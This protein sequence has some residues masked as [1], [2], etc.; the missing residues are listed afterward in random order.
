MTSRWSGSSFSRPYGTSP[1]D[2][3]NAKTSK[4][5]NA[6]REPEPQPEITVDTLCTATHSP[7]HSS[8]S[9]RTELNRA[10]RQRK[11]ILKKKFLPD[12]EPGKARR[13]TEGSQQDDLPRDKKLAKELIHADTHAEA[14]KKFSRAFSQRSRPELSLLGMFEYIKTSKLSPG[15]RSLPL[16]VVLLNMFRAAEDIGVPV[17]V[18]Q[19]TKLI[20]ALTS[21]STHCSHSWK[22]AL[23]LQD[24]MLNNGHEPDVPFYNAVLHTLRKGGKSDLAY[25]MLLKLLDEGVAV[26][27][28]SFEFVVSSYRHTGKLDKALQVMKMMQEAGFQPATETYNTALS[29]CKRKGN[30]EVAWKLLDE[31]EQKGIPRDTFS[32]SAAISAHAK[33]GQL[34]LAKQVHARM[35]ADGVKKNT[36]TYN[37]LLSVYKRE[38]NWEEAF[39][40]FEQMKMEGVRRNDTT[41]HNLIR[42]CRQHGAWRQATSV[43]DEMQ[44][45][46]VI[47]TAETMKQLLTVFISA[48]KLADA[49]KMKHMMAYRAEKNDNVFAYHALL[50]AFARTGAWRMASGIVDEMV[51]LNIEPTS[52]GS[53]CLMEAF[54]KVSSC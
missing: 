48:G 28:R 19:Y 2:L 44:V 13:R 37:A 11:K 1:R 18:K 40:L 27:D 3:S 15:N 22:I 25:Q 26:N 49:M 9:R 46:G 10:R 50:G 47:F 33:F 42:I 45:D 4:A 39:A 34:E 20:S 17:S 41:Y 7:P 36:H 38:G 51:S 43:R 52:Q 30:V 12:P 14:L 16:H 53:A 21:N 6:F 29:C 54:T 31:M 32:Y 24:E 23:Q 5:S 8:T 35:E